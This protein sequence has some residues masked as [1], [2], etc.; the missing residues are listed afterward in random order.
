MKLTI[1]PHTFALASPATAA[2][3]GDDERRA[4]GVPPGVAD[5]VHT[6]NVHM[7]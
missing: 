4:L 2:C 3:A 1:M 7:H 6:D 5:H